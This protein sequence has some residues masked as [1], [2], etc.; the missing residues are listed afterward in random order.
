MLGYTLE[1]I[2]PTY[3]QWEDL[4]HPDDLLSARQAVQDHL[5]GKTPI[6]RDEYRLR[7]KDGSYRWILDQGKIV[8]YDS[9][10]RP[11]RMTATHTDI[12]ELKQVEDQLRQLSSAVEHSPIAIMITDLDGKI[13][14]VNPKFTAA[15]GYT[16][17]EVCGQT[18]RVLKSGKTSP[19][20]YEQL[21]RTI[22]SG[23][24]WRGEFLNRRK[25]GRLYWEYSSISAILDSKGSITHFVSV[26]EDITAR[27]EAE[28]KIKRLNAG[29]EQLAMTDYLT[30]LY[31][32]R[33]FMQRGAEEFKRVR[34]NKQSLS[35]LMLDIDKFKEVNDTYGHEIGD[36]TLQQVAAVLKSNLR[37][38]DIIGRIGGEEFAV[39]LP[40]TSLDEAAVLAERI[41]KAITNAVF[42]T[43]S[44]VISVTVCVGVATYVSE[45][46]SIDDLLRN[47][48]VALYGAKHG[49]RN[50]VMKYDSDIDRTHDIA[51]ELGGR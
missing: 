40:H 38:V 46:S 27:K 31:N 41:R 18:P 19:E 6:H 15:T 26:N 39:L 36:M 23:K 4:V 50:R 32:R 11:L 24:E 45:M 49:G 21:W 3:E 25:D 7:A 37:E 2:N 30:S 43:S 22:L 14:Y 5:D 34:R 10:G 8:E 1:E 16:L 28:E 48:D 17:E 44:T 33:Y 47:A 20:V 51:P 13:E 35:I 12:T 9:Q 29:L 42:E